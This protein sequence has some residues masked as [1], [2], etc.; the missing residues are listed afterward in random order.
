M[1]SEIVEKFDSLLPNLVIDKSFLKKIEYFN[2]KWSHKNDDHMDFL[3]GNTIGVQ[4]V[5]FSKLDDEA[6]YNNIGINQDDIKNCVSNIKSID[7]TRIVSSNPHYIFLMYL[8]HKTIKNKTLDKN[9]QIELLR[10][11]YYTFAYRV[12]SGRMAHY[13]KFPLDLAT[14]NT[15]MERLSN[16]FILKRLGNWNELLKYRSKDIIPP[17]GIHSRSLNMLES[18]RTQYTI[19]DL[20]N[21]L[22]DIFKNIYVVIIEVKK[23]NNII[24][25][26]SKVDESGEEGPSFKEA[27]I[28]SDQYVNYLKSILYNKEDLIKQDLLMLV[29]KR[30][31]IIKPSD[32]I[33]ALSNLNKIDR[34]ELDQVI[35]GLIPTVLDFLYRNKIN[36][37]YSRNIFTIINMVK[38]YAIAHTVKDKYVIMARDTFLDYIPKLYEKRQRKEI[39]FN[40]MQALFVYLVCRSFYNK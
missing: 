27:I 16:K 9:S 23:D 38:G 19:V 2:Y 36:S 34:N 1:A 37:N 28:N 11:L 32:L 7:K 22:K 33:S 30:I 5:R 25:L 21:K 12:I 3:G 26:D 17:S 40:T 39:I 35:D 15:V 14:A 31:G 24:K 18:D 6:F 29:V 8:I 4:I 20:F 13:F 10:Q